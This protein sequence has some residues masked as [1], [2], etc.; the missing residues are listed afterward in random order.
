MYF[1]YYKQ[2]PLLLPLLLLLIAFASCKYKPADRKNIS[3]KNVIGIHYTEVKRRLHTGRSF[4][5]HGYEVDPAWKMFFMSKDSASVFSPDSNRFLT[6]PVTLDHDSLFSVANTWLRAKKVTK[7]SMIFQVMQVETNVIYLLRSNVYMTFYADD[8]IKKLNKSLTDLQKPDRGD[9]V[10]VRER[11]A[12][13][14][15]YPDSLFAA[16]QPVILKS[17]SPLVKVEKEEVIAQVMNH[18]NTSESYLD[19]I[20][21][22]TIHKAYQDFSYSFKVLVDV[23]GQMHFVKNL[24]YTFPEYRESTIRIIKGIIDG[25]LKVYIAV[26]PGETL[27]IPH[28]SLI[29][30]NVVGRKK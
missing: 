27:A 3:F 5:N 25:Y 6:F 1:K 26:K 4:D 9:T 24:V 23:N 12:L 30:I 20:Y 2:S 8:Y 18:Y 29:T 16:R 7:D 17:K 11:A 22:I 10:F 13:A 19:P 14:N 21:D 28:T 15:K